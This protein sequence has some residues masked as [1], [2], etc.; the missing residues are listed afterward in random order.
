MAK[1]NVNFKE[2]GKEVG[3]VLKFF[4]DKSGTQIDDEVIESIAEQLA[5]EDEVD[6]DEVVTSLFAIVKVV[7]SATANKFDDMG[8]SLAE[9]ALDGLGLLDKLEAKL[10]SIQ[11][12]EE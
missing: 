2:L 4:I 5:S 6:A 11:K 7:T 3:Q 9:S 8:V 12:E 10:N 1:L